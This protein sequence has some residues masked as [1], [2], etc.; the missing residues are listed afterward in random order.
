MVNLGPKAFLGLQ[1]ISN[2]KKGGDNEK[3]ISI[4]GDILAPYNVHRAKIVRP[5]VQL[6]GAI[7]RWIIKRLNHSKPIQQ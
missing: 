7:E 5:I 2:N 4:A 3:E 1:W 6:V